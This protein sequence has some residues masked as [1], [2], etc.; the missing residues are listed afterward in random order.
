MLFIIRGCRENNNGEGYK[1]L[2]KTGKKLVKV[3]NMP[4]F[5][6]YGIKYECYDSLFHTEY[7]QLKSSTTLTS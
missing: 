6:K 4:Y 7:S 1:N 2:K 3:K 5:Q